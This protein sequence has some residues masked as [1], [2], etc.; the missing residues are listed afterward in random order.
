MKKSLRN[1][2]SLA[3]LAVA[4]SA[5]CAQSSGSGVTLYGLVDLG[6][7][8]ADAGSVS[9]TRL[10][11]GISAGSRWGLKGTEELSPGWKAIFTLESR[12]EAD[13]GSM[14]N[15]GSVY[16]CGS[17]AIC[18]GVVLTAPYTSLP[19]ATQTALL[20]G[21]WAINDAAIRLASTVNSANALFD[22][23]AYVGLITPVGAFVVG[24]QYTPGYEALIKFNAFGD[25]FAGSP[26]Q[27][28]QT[29]IRANNAIQ[30]RVDRDGFIGALMYGMGGTEINRSE[31][32]TGPQSGDDFYGANLQY[33]GD[34]FGVAVG[35]NRNNTVTYAAPTESK[36]GLQTM[37]LGAYYALGPVKLFSSFL[38]AKNDNPVFTPGDILG[39]VATPGAT[40]A[41]LL[42]IVGG[43][44]VGRGDV[45]GLR[46]VAG[47]VNLKVFH[48]GAQWTVSP[49]GTVLLAY[50][51]A[52][53]TARSAWAT[54]DAKVDQFGLAY[55]HSL[56]KRT[57]L[58]GA[59]A[60]AN[61]KGQARAALGGA[62]YLG[63]L[64]T[65]QGVDSRVAQLGVRHSF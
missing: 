18:Q 51:Q 48:L 39:L 26:A 50:N 54:A 3:L 10:N 28:S 6:V 41:S 9:A 38:K 11:S 55:L 43:Q 13:N 7:E 36:K 35:Y 62:G 59:Y 32:P 4:A 12:I 31:R 30:Y 16:T 2:G 22:R 21:A 24:R 52:K 1:V 40:Q 34:V 33:A 60:L 46:G 61:N 8:R 49:S 44:Y 65:G 19:G 27:L 63:G 53:D 58:Y 57:Q 42:A 23:Q 47:P 14:T 29:T 45:D 37:S 25:G 17:P 20:G 15:N 56:S 5:A 64:T